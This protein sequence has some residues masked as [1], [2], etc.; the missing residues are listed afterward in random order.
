MANNI[1]FSEASIFAIY[2]FALVGIVMIF[3]HFVKK[4]ETF[5]ILESV[6]MVYQ[7]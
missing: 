1:F 6:L 3:V 7:E 5:T 4:H 2:L